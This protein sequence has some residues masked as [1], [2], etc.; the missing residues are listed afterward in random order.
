MQKLL[1][2][3]FRLRPKPDRASHR[4]LRFPDPQKKVLPDH[5]NRFPI[6]KIRTVIEMM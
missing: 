1:A 2:L 3:R 5:L 6:A 4:T